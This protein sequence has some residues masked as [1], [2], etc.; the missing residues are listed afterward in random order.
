[1]TAPLSTTEM[2]RALAQ[3]AFLETAQRLEPRL[4]P[5]LAAAG[6][7]G[8][9]Q[10]ASAYA[11]NVPWVLEQGRAA[12]ELWESVP[13]EE[14]KSWGFCMVGVWM[15]R[16][17]PFSFSAPAPDLTTVDRAKAK[18]TIRAAFD[19]ELEAFLDDCDAW[20][21]DAGWREPTRR[22]AAEAHLEWFVRYQVLGESLSAIARSVPPIAA[23][24]T[25]RET[26][27]KAV[28]DMAGLIELP[29][30]VSKGGRPRKPA[31]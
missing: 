14:G 10:W 21:A 27:G 15:P 12:L 22:P 18:E 17:Q 31:T 19:E 24:R 6:P 5:D 7:A 25:P 11:I 1:M 8:L 20:Y 4:L 13:A 26:V 16:M 28:R 9:A 23:K 29:L 30:R 2:N 3:Y